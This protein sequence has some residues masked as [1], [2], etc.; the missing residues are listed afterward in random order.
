MEQNYKNVAEYLLV[1][2]KGYQ[3]DDHRDKNGFSLFNESQGFIVEIRY[4]FDSSQSIQCFCYTERK[5][6]NQSL[7]A[8]SQTS[9]KGHI[10]TVSDVEGCL[11][12]FIKRMKVYFKD[13]YPNINHNIFLNSNKICQI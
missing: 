8:F 2:C 3:R 11:K 6:G 7:K 9:K 5:N 10:L 13:N 4:R 12:F 1:T